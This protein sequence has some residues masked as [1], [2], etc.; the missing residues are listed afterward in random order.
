MKMKNRSIALMLTLALVLSGMFAF[1]SCNSTGNTPDIT[2]DKENTDNIDNTDNTDNIDPTTP[3]ENTEGTGEGE[4]NTEGGEEPPVED[5][6]EPKPVVTEE[7]LYVEMVSYN[8]AF[9]EAT[10][11]N[12]TVY[13][14]GQTLEDYKISK[15]AERLRAFVEYFTPDILAL[16]EVNWKWWPTIIKNE[17]SIVNT[18]GYDWAGNQSAFRN[19][20]GFKS[21]DDDLYNLLLWNSEKY[22]EIKSGV[23]RISDAGQGANKSRMC[24]YAILKNR[25]TG[26]EILYASTH[27]CTRGND[28]TKKL[29]L[30]MAGTLAEKLKS[31]AEGRM[32]VVGG[33]FNADTP[34]PTYKYMTGDGGFSDARTT[35]SVRRNQK[36]NSARV[37]GKDQNWNTGKK[38]PIDHIFYLGESA[39]A[40]EWTVLTE[41][42]DKDNNV[43]TDINMIGINFDL[44]DHQGIYAKFKEV[45][46]IET[47]N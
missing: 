16:Q 36:L 1:A 3:P 9:Y 20:N 44:S 46:E 11:E 12:M 2:D 31:L 14:E 19:K 34:S 4:E 42:Y 8:I 43:T 7:D 22:E 32:I 17:D 18:L 15:R 28:A 39:T 40:E 38:T 5:T 33:D 24:T 10:S 21:S 41:T 6:E 25:A 23:F 47:E 35:A 26:I 37:W 45:Y 29:N 13:Y 27:L 30:E